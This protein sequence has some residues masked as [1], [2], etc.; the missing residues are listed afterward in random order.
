MALRRDKVTGQWKRLYSK[1]L[2]DLY[3]SPNIVQVIKPRRMRL[4]G[5]VACTGERRSVYR[6]LVHRPGGR[7]ICIK[8]SQIKI[9]LDY[10]KTGD[11]IWQ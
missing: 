3:T 8:E 2:Y 5:H 11:N 9:I 7:Q 1:K 10:N 6:I 4:A